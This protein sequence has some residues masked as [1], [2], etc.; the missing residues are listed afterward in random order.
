[1]IR[2]INSF[3]L[4]LQSKIFKPFT[5]M[6][7]DIYISRSSVFDKMPKLLVKLLTMYSIE[8]SSV[9]NLNNAF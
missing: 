3:Y 7:Q 4:Y 1:M 2:I 6:I 8:D 5:T 9:V